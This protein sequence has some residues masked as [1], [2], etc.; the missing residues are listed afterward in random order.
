MNA[1]PRTPSPVIDL[2]FPA[3]THPA[4]AIM[5]DSTRQWAMRFGLARGGAEADALARGQYGIFAARSYPDAPLSQAKLAADWFTWL[6]F[7]DDQ[8]EEGAHTSPEKWTLLLDSA[9]ATFTTGT[10]SGPLAGLPL[11]QAA[12]DLSQRFARF[13]EPSWM[14]RLIGNLTDTLAGVLREHRLRDEGS[15]P[16]LDQYIPLRRVTGSVIPCFDLIEICSQARLTDEAYHAPAFQEVAT[17]AVDIVSWTNDLYSLDKE[18][19][20]GNVCNLVLVLQRERGLDRDEAA[21]LARALINE[22]VDGLQAA[23][24]QLPQRAEALGLSRPAQDALLRYAAGIC[25]WTAGSNEWHAH[26][27]MRYHQPLPGSERRRA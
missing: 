15:S 4:A 26:S 6:F 24:R 12:A 22:R 7:A 13:A 16:T 3:R 20:C 9:R 23:T 14:R 19:A 1:Q 8:S 5:E 11:I 27:T 21:S 18:I 2:P 25:D 17:A 10:P